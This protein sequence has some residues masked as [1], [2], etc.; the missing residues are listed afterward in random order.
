MN[1][2]EVRH[3]VRLGQ[4]ACPA[5]CLVVAATVWT[6]SS[7]DNRGAISIFITL[8]AGGLWFLLRASAQWLEKTNKERSELG[9]Q[10]IQSQKVMALGELSTGIA[11]EINNPLNIIMQEAEL[12]RMDLRGTPTEED[13]KEVRGSLDV[14]QKQVTR[15][16]DITRKLLDFARNMQ[17]V[18][19]LADINRLIEDMI[20]LIERE[21]GPKNIQ[22]IKTLDVELPMVKTDPPLLRQVFLNLLIN[23]V[24]AIGNNGLIFVSTY[25]DDAKVCAEVRDT[26]PGITAHDMER[27]FTPFFTTKQ[28]GQGTGL[29]LS[30]S[31]RII[32]QLGGDIA[33]HSDPGN[34]AEFTVSIPAK[35]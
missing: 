22:I 13:M 35:Q 17:P 27:V 24:Q 16:S 5:I 15:C 9:R 21:A 19:Q 3:V 20:I 1:L 34:G 2:F 11:H 33:V 26:G 8:L 6:T 31:L 14:I 10:L 23:A 30:V 18:S 12:M 7:T 25:C 32:N 28:P 4:Y 29:G